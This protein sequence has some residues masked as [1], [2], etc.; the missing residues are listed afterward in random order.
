MA[1]L[2][3][4]LAYPPVDGRPAMSY[5]ASSYSALH[6]GTPGDLDHYRRVCEGASSI[7]ELG[8]GYGRVVTALAASG[9]TIVGVELD[10]QMLALARAAVETLAPSLRAGI[11]LCHGDMRDLSLPQRFERVLV[12]FGGLYCMLDDA[13]LDAALRTVTHHLAPGGRAAFDVYRADE[14][15]ATAEP[16]DVPA[17]AHTPLTRV[18]VDGV[19]YEVLERSRWDRDHQRI[20]VEYL[21]VSEQGDAVVGTIEQRYLLEPQLHAA[22]ARAGLR[23]VEQHGGFVAPEPRREDEDED[24]LLVLVVARVGE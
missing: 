10:P 2:G 9:R 4:G 6:R 20:D 7:L 12:P 14:F 24:E 15:H 11:T 17:D 18:E 5:P 21:Y 16:E 19:P 3:G 1:R 13:E 22:L 8:C 23:V